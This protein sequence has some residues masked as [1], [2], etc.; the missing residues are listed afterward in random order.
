MYI[1][2]LCVNYKFILLFSDVSVHL[3]EYSLQLA[4]VENQYFITIPDD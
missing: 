4:R 3:I 2:T 1:N